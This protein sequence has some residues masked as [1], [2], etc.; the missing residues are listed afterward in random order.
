M[1]PAQGPVKLHSPAIFSFRHYLQERSSSCCQ[2]EVF[3][4]ELYGIFPLVLLFPTE[5]TRRVLPFQRHISFGWV[6]EWGWGGVQVKFYNRKLTFWS[7]KVL[8]F[9]QPAHA[10]SF[11]SLQFWQMMERSRNWHSSLWGKNFNKIILK[12]NTFHIININ[13]RWNFNSKT[14]NIYDRP[15]FFIMSVWNY[16]CCFSLIFQRLS[17]IP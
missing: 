12:H 10:C 15:T 3:S 8:V 14:N 7:R 4:L 2:K 1:S 16:A 6:G 9:F 17:A 11:T 5:A 13:I